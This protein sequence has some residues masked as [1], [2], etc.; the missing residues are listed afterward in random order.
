MWQEFAEAPNPARGARG[1]PGTL[2]RRWNLRP[3]TPAASPA[4]TPV[5]AT[6]AE[7]AG[8]HYDA[9][10]LVGAIVQEDGTGAVLMFA[11]MNE[12]ALRRTLETG[13]MWY[14][15]RSRQE[16]W[17]KGETSGD[18]Q[19]LPRGPLRLRRRCAAV[20]GRAGGP[21]C[22]PHRRAELLLPRFRGRGHPGPRLTGPMPPAGLSRDEF[23][24][25]ARDHTVVPVWREVLADLETPV[26]AFV[27]L[28][29]AGAD[30]P[31]AFL[32][33]S[34]EH[35]E[36]WGRFSFLGR[37]PELT[38]IARGR[39]VEF[40]GTPPPGVPS[41]QGALAA[42]EALLRVYRAPVIDELPPFHG[43]VVGYLGYDV[44]RE[45]ERLPD[46]PPDSSGM[47]D[48]VM[49][50]TGHVTAFDH[51][52]QRLY[53]IENVFVDADAGDAAASDAY[54]AACAAPRRPGRRT[55]S[56]VALRA[57]AAAGGRPQRAAGVHV[58]DAG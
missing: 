28:A 54:D 38:L 23:V 1:A 18:R 45:I 48:A 29:G 22:V 41:D 20:R 19:Y 14:W 5:A 39:S 6:D 56:S 2:E 37:D 17:C 3:K 43:G 4:V 30:D 11:W 21:G 16:Y 25:L 13:R 31:P 26:S 53:L 33:E 42:I 10:G 50:V 12:A 32:L 24:A 49:S 40:E 34:V 15:S 58:D 44:V 55:G 51:F 57:V 36:R 27:K 9:D 47:P 46:V 35:A 7:L 52:R 8:V